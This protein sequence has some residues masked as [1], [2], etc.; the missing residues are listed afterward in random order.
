LASQGR[1]SHRLQLQACTPIQGALRTYS[2]SASRCGHLRWLAASTRF[3]RK[4][5]C[6]HRGRVVRPACSMA[7]SRARADSGISR[8]SNPSYFILRARAKEGRSCQAGV[9][10]WLGGCPTC[11]PVV[12]PGLCWIAVETRPVAWRCRGNACVPPRPLPKD[13][14]VVLTTT[15][16]PSPRARLRIIDSCQCHYWLC[17]PKLQNRIPLFNE[18]DSGRQLMTGCSGTCLEELHRR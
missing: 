18:S 1:E 6:I 8:K 17:S 15:S 2:V 10:L 7:S 4:Q 14:R 3:R 5:L 12:L 16:L 11:C 9:G 13:G